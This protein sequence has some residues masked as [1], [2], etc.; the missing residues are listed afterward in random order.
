[1]FIV[2]KVDIKVVKRFFVLRYFVENLLLICVMFKIRNLM[3]EVSIVEMGLIFLFFGIFWFIDLF[4]YF[5]FVV[6]IIRLRV[7][8]E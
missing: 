4:R 3:I 7:F 5:V 6:V 1:M 8:I 2:M